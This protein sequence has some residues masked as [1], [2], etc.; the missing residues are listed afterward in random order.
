[1]K[2]VLL[3]DTVHPALTAGLTNLGYRVEDLAGQSKEAIL[4]RLPTAH[5]IIIRSRFTLNEAF[6]QG[7]T[8][9]KFIGRVGAGTEN[10]DVPWCERRGI[11]CL[12]APEGNRDAVGEHALGMLLML[13]NHLHRADAE[14]RQG[15]WRRAENRGTELAGKTLGIIGYGHMGSAMAE[16]CSG[17]GLKILAH[18]KYKTGYA[19]AFAEEVGLEEIQASADIIS[20]HLP[21]TVETHGMVNHPFFKGCRKKPV[22]INT[23]RGP[24]VPLADLERALEE[25][26]ISGA[27]LDVLEVEPK[28]FEGLFDQDLPASFRRLLAR[29]DVVFSPHIAGWTHESN[30]RMSNVILQ[31]IA[32]LSAEG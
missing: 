15:I 26:L 20:L 12:K 4:A 24:I 25:G 28:S 9:L 22:L 13:Q 16:K 10:I 1:M 2:T 17:L 8:A 14:V 31:K 3:L 32:Q 11:T 7:A 29:K 5:G 21:L 6:L 23:A 19:P 27:C 18:D 30:E